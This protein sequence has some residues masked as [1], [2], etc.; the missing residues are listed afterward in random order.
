MKFSIDEL[1]LIAES[2][3][4]GV[5]YSRSESETAEFALLLVKLE[6]GIVAAKQSAERVEKLKSLPGCVF[7]YCPNRPKCEGKCG[8]VPDYDYI[9]GGKT[10]ASNFID[11]CICND[12]SKQSPRGYCKVCHADSGYEYNCVDC[13]KILNSKIELKEDENVRCADCSIKYFLKK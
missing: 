8:N 10:P 6:G 11:E 7:H 9:K 3:K 1:K 12:I 4:Y 2:L 13:G 5:G